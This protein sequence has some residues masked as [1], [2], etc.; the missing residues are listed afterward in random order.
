V[1]CPGR[2]GPQG[3]KALHHE[4]LRR[5]GSAAAQRSQLDPKH[6]FYANWRE[7]EG[8]MG[9]LCWPANHIPQTWPGSE[10]HGL[11]RGADHAVGHITGLLS[12]CH[13][14]AATI[15]L[16][17]GTCGFTGTSTTAASLPPFP[18]VCPRA[19][20]IASCCSKAVSGSIL[21]RPCRGSHK[22]FTYAWV[23]IS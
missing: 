21:A 16:S 7:R 8:I 23:R 5:R 12:L 6:V 3:C 15:S 14:R 10:I 20:A 4:E 18:S 22:G 13:S 2:G 9:K 17:P 11:E 19:R 1:D